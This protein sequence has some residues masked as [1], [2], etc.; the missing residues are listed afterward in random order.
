MKVYIGKYRNR[1]NCKLHTRYMNIKYS[2]DWPEEQSWFENLLE[3]TED[4]IQDFYNIFNKVYFDKR[5][6][7]TKYIKI[8]PWDTWSMDHTLSDIILPMLIQL[9]ET[10]H[11]APYVD[12]MDVPEHLW[13]TGKELN[14][15]V[16]DTHFKRWEWVLDEMI[17]AFSS[18]VR[19]WEKD[20]YGPFIEGENGGVMGG[21]FEWVDDEGR[22]AHQER[23]SNGFKLFGKYFENLWD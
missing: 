2:F 3:K 15:S 22:K 10:Q 1:L 20:Y 4:K 11:G 23:M 16:D 13:P 5:A 8:D 18:K 6:D 12:I 14:D 17:F 21:Q 9:K 19:N 7:Q